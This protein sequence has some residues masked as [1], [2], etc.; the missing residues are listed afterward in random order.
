LLERIARLCTQFTD[1]A[2]AAARF[3]AAES[4]DRIV[5]GVRAG[6]D[7]AALKSDLDNLDNAFARNGIDNVTTG[8][9]IYREL[10]GSCGHPVMRV[11][12]CPAARPC[13]RVEMAAGAGCGLTGEPLTSRD[14]QS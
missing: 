1:L 13:P 10:P 5:T 4:L 14:V 12:V 11:W 7:P 3:G 2:A 6:A 8:P 9:R